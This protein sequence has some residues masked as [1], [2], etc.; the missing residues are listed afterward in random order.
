MILPI[1][2]IDFEIKINRITRVKTTR[3][4]V[5][6]YYDMTILDIKLSKTF[7]NNVKFRRNY[8]NSSTVWGLTALGFSRDAVKAIEFDFPDWDSIVFSISGDF[9]DLFIAE[10]DPYYRLV[11]YGK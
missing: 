7:K 8:I 9:K 3:M 4:L 1:V 11:V 6:E 10:F 2:D 5:R